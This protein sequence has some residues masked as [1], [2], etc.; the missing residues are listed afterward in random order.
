MPQLSPML[1]FLMFIMVLSAYFILLS[2]LS[3]KAPFVLTT[4]QKKS[5]Q[6]SFGFFK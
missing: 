5:S 4:K 6:G 2:S 3:K 1:G